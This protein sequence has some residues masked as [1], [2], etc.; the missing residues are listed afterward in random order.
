MKLFLTVCFS[1]AFIFSASEELRGVSYVTIKQEA[2]AKSCCDTSHD[3]AQ[4]EN[5]CGC[6]HCSACC[7]LVASV[8]I[9]QNSSFIGAPGQK[10]LSWVLVKEDCTSRFYKPSLPPPKVYGV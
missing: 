1:L 6:N 3:K 5:A 2:K 10:T 9:T 8:A 7:L 4:H